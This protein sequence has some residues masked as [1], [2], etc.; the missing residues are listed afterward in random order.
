MTIGKGWLTIIAVLVA[1]AVLA[2]DSEVG[3]TLRDVFSQL[4]G[5]TSSLMDT[6]GSGAQ[7]VGGWVEE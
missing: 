2:P 4:R 7:D 1:L 6:A 3:G 5:A